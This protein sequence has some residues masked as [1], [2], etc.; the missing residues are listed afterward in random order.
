LG[1][2][3]FCSGR[4]LRRAPFSSL[5]LALLCSFLFSVPC[6][7]LFLALLCALCVPTSVTGACPDLVGVLPSLFSSPPKK[8]KNRK[9]LRPAADHHT[10][11]LRQPLAGGESSLGYKPR[12]TFAVLAPLAIPHQGRPRKTRG[13]S[14]QVPETPP[15]PSRV[16]FEFAGRAH[17]REFTPNPVIN[18]TFP[19]VNMKS[20]K[21]SLSPKIIFRCAALHGNLRVYP[22]PRRVPHPSRFMRRVGSYNRTPPPLFSPLL[23]TR[24]LS[25]PGQGDLRAIFSSSSPFSVP[26]VSFPLRPLCYRP[27]SLRISASGVSPTHSGPCL[28]ALLPPFELSTPPHSFFT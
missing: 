20:T 21:I 9:S 12:E 28:L 10:G 3:R 25:R 14:G 22:E 26:S 19:L 18:L 16:R 2:S 1:S 7:S 24:R 5:F 17:C 13:L 23:C 8:Q 11:S 15:N 6:S 4:L 27:S